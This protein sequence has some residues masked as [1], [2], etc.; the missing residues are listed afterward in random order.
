MRK[1]FTFLKKQ[2]TAR[3]IALGFVLA[4]LIGAGLLILPCS[5]KE[6]VSLSY[7]DSLYTSTSAV[8]VTG[9]IVVDAA[10]T[11]TL[12]GQIILCTLI[13][14]GGLGVTAIG[15]GIILA[16]GKKMDLKGRN[17]IHDAMNLSSGKAAVSFIK[18]LFLTTL[19]IQATGAIL[20]F[21]VFIQDF[22]IGKAVW[23]SIFHSVA[24]FNNAGFDVLGG[25]QGLTLYQN[26]IPLNLVTCVLIFLGGIGFLVIKE[27]LVKKFRWKK[28]SMHSKVVLSVSGFLI[29]VGTLLIKCSE[30]IS[31]MGAFFTSVSART[32]GFSTYSLGGFTR[33]GLLIVSILM[34]IGASP[35]ST[36]GGIKTST[37]FVLIKG[38]KSAATNTSEKAFRYAIPKEAFKKAAVI[39]L[40]AFFAVFVSTWMI[41]LFQPELLLEDVLFEMFSAFGTVGLS[42]GITPVLETGS[43][44][45]SIFMMFIG[46]LGPLT[47]ASIW[48]FSR[49]ERVKFPEG[50]IAIG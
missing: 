29:V 32:A 38:I 18:S 24:S 33:A 21:S 19:V 44:I 2:P 41:C 39:V 28:L 5:V 25:F 48:H 13:E 34:L 46:R 23:I 1:M 11:F 8:C 31:W 17:L 42:T 20:S 40:L 26:N 12:F 14:V 3:I 36:G 50:N 47:I 10:D 4:I 6:G 7:I 43:K 45:V 30:D 27:V 49:G 15:A 16:I 37:F 35:G 22:D 9:L